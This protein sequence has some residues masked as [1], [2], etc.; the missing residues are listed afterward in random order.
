MTSPAV[1]YNPTTLK[2]VSQSLYV[3]FAGGV[4]IQVSLADWLAGGSSES[5]GLVQIPIAQ[6]ETNIPANGF[7]MTVGSSTDPNYPGSVS[8]SFANFVSWWQQWQKNVSN[9][10]NI[11]F[12]ANTTYYCIAELY[13][14]YS[15][16]NPPYQA[17]QFSTA[18]TNVET[19]FRLNYTT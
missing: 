18:G 1:I 2:L 16:P 12:N 13:E 19:A 5:I 4:Q 17:A 3:G 14:T 6:Y 10:A 7:I 11:N 8:I 9:N 15:N